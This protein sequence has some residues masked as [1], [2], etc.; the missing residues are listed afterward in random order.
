[1]MTEAAA[2][3]TIRQMLADWNAASDERRAAATAAAE[4]AALRAEW[5]Q[6]FLADP[7]DAAANAARTALTRRLA[8]ATLA[9]DLGTRVG[10][11]TVVAGGWSRERAAQ[12]DAAGAAGSPAWYAAL[13]AHEHATL[14]GDGKAAARHAW[15]EC[16]ESLDRWVRYEGWT[17]AGCEAHGFV[18]ADCRRLVQT[19]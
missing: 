18:C 8:A 1:M 12:A 10:A 6:P 9:A 3:E 13:G 19:G 4:L 7:R 11:L 5:D 15:C 16:P 14:T 2:R 17:A